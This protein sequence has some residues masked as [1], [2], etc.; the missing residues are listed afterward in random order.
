MENVFESNKMIAWCIINIVDNILV[1][2]PKGIYLANFVYSEPKMH[3]LE[4]APNGDPII[5]ELFR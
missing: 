3:E 5:T 1:Y 2:I 4:K